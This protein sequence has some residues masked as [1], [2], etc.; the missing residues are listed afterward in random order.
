MRVID[1]DTFVVADGS[2]KGGKV[3]LIGVDAPET[4]NS[5]KRKIGFYGKEAKEYL[6]KLIDGKQVR[7]AYDAGKRD[8]YGRL[9]AY[10]YVGNLFINADL[11]KKGYA[12]VYT[13]PPNVKYAELFVEL[14][15][16]ARQGKRGLWRK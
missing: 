3:R 11:V 5:G 2:P 12:Q 4:R 9:L 14:E 16:E 1:G 8:R 15:R 13:V 7:L 6:H 10:V